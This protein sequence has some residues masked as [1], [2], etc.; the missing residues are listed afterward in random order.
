MQ[1]ENVKKNYLVMFINYSWGWGS[2]GGSDIL[3][4]APSDKSLL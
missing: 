1:N 4:I 3:R 2:F